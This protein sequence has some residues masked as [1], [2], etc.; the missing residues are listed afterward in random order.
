MRIVISGA[1]GVIGSS[2]TS[3]LQSDGHDV[4]RLVRHRPTH[5]DEREW[6]PARGRLDAAVLDGVDAVVNLSGAGIGDKR[7]S[8][9]RRR[10]IRSSRLDTTRLLS[11]AMA[12][13]D[14]PPRV[15]V[16]QSAIGFYGDR[17]D[18]VLTERSAPGAADAFLTGL[19]IEWEQAADAARSA[20][21]RVVHPRTGL[22]LTPGKQLLGKLL[23][24][25]KLGLGGPIG[26]GDQWWSWISLPDEIAAL[27]EIL[28][29]DL[30]GP[31]NLVAPT[32]VR[33][34]DFAEALGRFV[35]KPAV[36]PVPR[37]AI[38]AAMG[39]EMADELSLSSTRV[40][41][42][43]LV[44]HGFQFAH[45]TLDAAFAALLAPRRTERRAS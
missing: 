35:R 26:G 24:L 1:S 6:D 18:E 40:L 7:W 3:R 21:I 34:R 45:E 29:S 27:C 36:V 19:T 17:G 33:N 20:G 8:A 2:L 14:A 41:P 30:A 23:P 5:A 15:F 10:E 13:V 25:F 16:S 11:E 28:E 31:V 22:V 4:V 32:P 37:I 12:S 44:D 42:E 39:R 43:R 38:R 9:A